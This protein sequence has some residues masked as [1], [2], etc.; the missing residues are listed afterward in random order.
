MHGRE[1]GG[2]VEMDSDSSLL[3]AGSVQYSDPEALLSV[4][5]GASYGARKGTQGKN[6]GKQG[7]GTGTG[8]HSGNRGHGGR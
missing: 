6:R 1:G 3:R 7:I 8:S 5:H 4:L 2:Q